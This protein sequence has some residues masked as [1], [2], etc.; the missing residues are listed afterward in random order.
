MCWKE[1]G[2]PG[3]SAVNPELAN[4]LRGYKNALD[5]ALMATQLITGSQSSDTRDLPPPPPPPALPTPMTSRR[6]DTI[7]VRCCIYLQ[8]FVHVFLIYFYFC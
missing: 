5:A 7:E 8:I 3:L 4:I 6:N 1:L 2:V